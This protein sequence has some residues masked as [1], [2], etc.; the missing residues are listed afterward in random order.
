MSDDKK[1][2]AAIGTK[3]IQIKIN[4]TM[5]VGQNAMKIKGEEMERKHAKYFKFKKK[6]NVRP[7]FNA[8][9]FPSS[10]ILLPLNSFPIPPNSL[11]HAIHIT[12]H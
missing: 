6:Q 9:V 8:H 1:G 11:H 12:L 7:K 5:Y 4:F 2:K 3:V 10:S